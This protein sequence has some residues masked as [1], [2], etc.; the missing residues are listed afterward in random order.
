MER[1]FKDPLLPTKLNSATAR[2][3]FHGKPRRNPELEASAVGREAAW[4]GGRSWSNWSRRPVVLPHLDPF[5]IV[6]L[7]AACQCNLRADE[8]LRSSSPFSSMRSA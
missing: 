1:Q 4:A 2:I 3:L 7:G 8:S 6:G 5:R